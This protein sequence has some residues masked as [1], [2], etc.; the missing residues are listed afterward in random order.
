MGTEHL[1]RLAVSLPAPQEAGH[2][3]TPAPGLLLHLGHLAPCRRELLPPSEFDQAQWRLNHTALV[4]EERERR[5][6]LGYMVF[7]K[8]Q[9]GFRLRGRYAVQVTGYQYAVLLALPE[10]CGVQFRGHIAYPNS[11][12][13]IPASAVDG[14]FVQDLAALIRRLA[15]ETPARRVPSAGEY[16]IC[17]IAKADCPARINDGPPEKGTT[18]DF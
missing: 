10:Y 2:A 9:N 5:E 1:S 3:N 14:K 13:G 6:E 18:A 15:A 11:Q 16:R 4:D 8:V 17:D 12:V 7:T